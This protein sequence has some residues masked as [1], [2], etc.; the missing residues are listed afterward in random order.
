M[1]S[2]E[3]VLMAF[4]FLNG[5]IV[6]DGD[7]KPIDCADCPCE[8]C[9]CH[10]SWEEYTDQ[11]FIAG[12]QNAALRTYE[13]PD[14]VANSPWTI[15]TNGLR[16]DFEESADDQPRNTTF[17]PL[18]F[19][20]GHGATGPG[21]SD[22]NPYRQYA[23]A[24]GFIYL[25]AAGDLHIAW[26]GL[27]EQQDPE[28]EF[29]RIKVNGTEVAN[30]HAPGGHLQC[31]EMA[32]VVSSPMGVTTVSLAAG[33]HEILIEADTADSWFHNGAYYEF[34]LTGPCSLVCAC[35]ADES[36]LCRPELTLTRIFPIADRAITA[37]DENPAYPEW[38][39]W[40]TAYASS[41]SYVFEYEIT[42]CEGRT[43]A[44][45]LVREDVAS[46]YINDVPIGDITDWASLPLTGTLRFDLTADDPCGSEASSRVIIVVV[47]SES[48]C[49]IYDE[50]LTCCRCCE[51]TGEITLGGDTVPD[52][53]ELEGIA[54][55]GSCT[56][57]FGGTTC[58]ASNHSYCFV[59]ITFG[60][61][62]PTQCSEGT[63][64]KIVYFMDWD[65]LLG[66]DG[67]PLENRC[68]FPGEVVRARYDQGILGACTCPLV[69]VLDALGCSSEEYPLFNGG[70]NSLFCVPDP[71]VYEDPEC[72]QELICPPE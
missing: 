71:S 53:P 31:A 47:D 32:P 55:N 11:G 8:G 4:W 3:C 67:T 36:C 14:D 65:G 72:Y 63:G 51:P 64:N 20:P 1:D 49:D 54:N 41:C 6:V 26:S 30:A 50:V 17:E 28:F 61:G 57:G 13:A 24:R 60:E 66:R 27:G 59:T 40:N 5:A 38:E 48:C 18:V 37:C 25:L 10:V 2:D 9:E 62:S 39:D 46:I 21:C 16:C 43:L 69:T 44:A 68:Y 29:M 34:A 42:L 7:G 23:S 19:G 33:V 56:D 70:L 35:K 12:G 15:T 22:Y 52:L 45:I 58:D